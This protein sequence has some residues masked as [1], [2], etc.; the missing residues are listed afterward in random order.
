MK[1]IAG[2]PTRNRKTAMKIAVQLREIADLVYIIGKDMEP[3][4]TE[5]E[6]IIWVEQS[7]ETG[8]GYARNLIYRFALE[9]D[10][11]YCL[12]SDDDLKFDNKV[13]HEL[14][15][16][17]E[18]CPWAGA[19]TSAPHMY[20]VW[21]KDTTSNREWILTEF[22]KQLW[23]LKMST[24]EDVFTPLGFLPFE[25]NTMEDLCLGLRLWQHGY[26]TVQIWKAFEE[27]FTHNPFIPRKSKTDA[28]G[29]QLISE[30]ESEFP[31]S[32][33]YMSPIF[34]GNDNVLQNL[35]LISEGTRHY[36]RYNWP[37][38]LRKAYARTGAL[39]Y[40]DSKNHQL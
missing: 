37:V 22:P 28:Q 33:E 39:G 3:M 21:N 18:E 40:K 24:I 11:D 35:K 20:R 32:V 15:R 7:E 34:V 26:P 36:V 9:N 10:A 14:V 30:R 6:G 25:L 29:G 2:I 31:I 27:K 8:L 12:Q 19:V 1:I 4:E 13:L 5:G 23:M 17:A 16:L 38:M